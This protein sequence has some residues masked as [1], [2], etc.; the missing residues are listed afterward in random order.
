MSS[1]E[2][3]L[4]S[5]ES[6]SKNIDGDHDSREII[7]TFSFEYEKIGKYTFTTTDDTRTLCK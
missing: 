2:R 5:I 7:L 6:L 4:L 3:N 1:D